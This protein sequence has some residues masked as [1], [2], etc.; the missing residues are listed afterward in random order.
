LEAGFVQ[1][2]ADNPAYRACWRRASEILEWLSHPQLNTE[3]LPF[4]LLAAASYQIAGYPARADALLLGADGGG[5]ESLILRSFL[6]SDFPGLLDRLLSFWQSNATLDGLS[7]LT[8][9]P[10]ASDGEWIARKAVADTVSAL[11]VLCAWVRWGDENRLT[12][13]LSKLKAISK[14]FLHGQ[15]RFSWLLARLS[16]VVAEEYTT[17]SLRALL[18]NFGSVSAAGGV[19]LERYLR[20]AYLAKKAVAWPSQEIGVARLRAGRS[21]ALCTPTGS[22]KTAVA[23]LAILQGLFAR[24]ASPAPPLLS[25]DPA[26]LCLYLVP[27]RALAAEV[28]SKLS[29]VFRRLSRERVVVT[30]LYGGTDWGPTDA[31]LTADD[32]TV[33][34]C[35]FEKAEALM[36]FLGPLFLTRVTL[37]VLDEAH[38]VQF[39]GQTGALYS[40]ESRPLRLEALGMR[41][42]SYVPAERCRVVAL[43]AVAAGIENALSAWV[44]NRPDEEPARSDY[45]STRQLIGRLEFSRT[46]GYRI[47]YDRLDGADLEFGRRGSADSPFVP[48]PFANPPPVAGNRFTGSPAKSLRPALFWAAMHLATPDANG[49]RRGVLISIPQQI[50][51]YADDFLFLLDNAWQSAEMPSFFEEPTGGD[52]RQVWERCLRSCQDYFGE[53]SAEYRLLNRGIVVHHGKMPG[54][55]AR[56]LVEVV[57]AGVASLVMATS[58]LSEGV[59]LPFETVLIPTLR[60]GQ[61]FLSPR[62]FGNLIGRAGRPGLAT[63]GQTLVLL[64][65]DTIESRN[66]WNMLTALSGGQS[67]ANSRPI[68]PLAALLDELR[69][70][71]ENVNPF[72]DD[73]DFL[74]WLEETSPRQTPQTASEDDHE[75]ATPIN[76][77]DTLD[78]LLLAA[79]VEAEQAGNQEL[80]PVDLEDQLRRLWRRT[81]AAVA[82]NVEGDKEQVF[83]RRGVALSRNIIP[84]RAERVRLYRTSL[85]P[86]SAD[87]FLARHPLIVAQLQTGG[88]Y[89]SW[90]TE[91]KIG[92]ITE[93]ARRIG[94]IPRFRFG[95]KAGRQ[96]VDWTDV[97]RWWLAPRSSRLAPTPKQVSAWHDYISKNFIYKLN[98][99]IGSVISLVFN[100]L[101]GDQLAPTRLEEWPSSGLPWAAL[102]LKELITWGTVEPVAAYILGKGCADTRPQAEALATAYHN[103]MR[104]GTDDP[105]DP[106]AIRR[107][108][109]TNVNSFTEDERL[110]TPRVFRATL[111]LDFA[112]Q[113]QSLWR[114]LPVVVADEIRWMDPAGYLMAISSL[115]EAGLDPDAARSFDFVLD[116][117]RRA[118]TSARYF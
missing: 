38:F 69:S 21:F 25:L 80:S 68:S 35:T 42:L 41:V 55:M 7:D 115:P 33:L 100:E 91:E 88:D 87:S 31:W 85:P 82:G 93:V 48:T 105:L 60:R 46:T 79:T 54:L 2:E 62:E 27:S 101:H 107:W 56:L 20:L 70:S 34:I 40:A 39:D 117:N 53:R 23:E 29:R 16:C 32:P 102:W 116:I 18:A 71:W 96:V 74:R 76:A 24:M 11:G 10:E 51:G 28:E 84:D 72:G 49:R 77:L 98:W 1:R 15:D 81:F 111:A 12:S 13:A 106:T 17:H 59:N 50:G 97:L 104:G 75:V 8:P 36:R 63:E 110:D 112:G 61:A 26:P 5:T 103:D 9:T 47:A 109:Q 66:Y 99:G 65:G 94:T 37:V 4:R 114:V 92:Y 14:V 95:P 78:A 22:G 118:V 45:R 90:N 6:R 108:V 30:G 67:A 58:T 86:R 52:I 19:A 44:T 73:A 89:A 3:G 64:G 43:S 57:Q 83:V 113:A